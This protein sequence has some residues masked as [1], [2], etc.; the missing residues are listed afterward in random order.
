MSLAVALTVVLSTTP[1]RSTDAP[2]PFEAPVAEGPGW[3]VDLG[4]GVIG[5]PRFP[6]AKDLRVLPIPAFDIRYRDRFFASVRDG[7]GLNLLRFEGFRAGPVVNAAF[8]RDDDKPARA[9][10]GLG[11][12]D[13]T[14]EP[15]AFAAYDFGEA[16]GIKVEA[17]NGVNGHEGL[18]VEGALSLNAPPL[19]D[20]RLFVS[21]GPK[22]AYYDE[23][24]SRSYFGVT[25]VQ[26][27]RS[28]Y[29]AF[30]PDDGYE[31]GV[32]AGAAYRV[33]ERVT[34][35]AFGEYGRLLG[36]VKRSPIVRGRYGSRD[37]FTAGAAL[38]YRFA[39]GN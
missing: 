39:F 1:S 10:R 9:L 6:G 11:D 26:S 16:A 14:V 20:G 3:R 21:G 28:G 12:V 5:V 7:I 18:I 24:Y 33:T 23:D 34:L 30:R 25:P 22:I 13:F 2:Q 38:T 27:L 8:P 4:A 36:D 37:Q 29:A 15:G 17:R 35:A 32:V 19:L 31:A